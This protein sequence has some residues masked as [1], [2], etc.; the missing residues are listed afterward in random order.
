MITMFVTSNIVSFLT[1]VFFCAVG[2]L[3]L[4][5]EEDQAAEVDHKRRH[6][7][8]HVQVGGVPV[9]AYSSKVWRVERG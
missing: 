4:C 6:T 5:G 2:V 1:G 8:L 3:F 9:E 7:L